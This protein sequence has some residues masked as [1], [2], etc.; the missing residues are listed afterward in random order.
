[1]L[2][3]MSQKQLLAYS[4]KQ[5][6]NGKHKHK[7]HLCNAIKIKS[8][9]VGYKKHKHSWVKMKI[10]NIFLIIFLHVHVRDV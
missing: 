6:E 2:E 4:K 1:M 3:Q 8:H 5:M 7:K 10:L 9:H